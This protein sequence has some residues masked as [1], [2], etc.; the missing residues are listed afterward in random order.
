MATSPDTYEIEELLQES[1]WVRAL[2]T[3][4]TA[5]PEDADDPTE[6][7]PVRGKLHHVR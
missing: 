6:P 1:S 3:R 2:A 4:L 5:T 7:P